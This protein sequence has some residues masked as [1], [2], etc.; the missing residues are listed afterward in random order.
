MARQ[1]RPEGAA[2][3]SRYT[4]QHLLDGIATWSLDSLL[5]MDE[6]FIVAV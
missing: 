5:R 4:E 6:E 2:V 3:E 1:Q